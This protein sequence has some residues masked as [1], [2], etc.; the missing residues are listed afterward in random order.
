MHL[1]GKTGINFQMALRSVLKNYYR[2]LNKTFEMPDYYGGDKK[3]DGWVV[4]DGLFYQIYGPTRLK[5]SLKK[6]IHDK[7]DE[8]LEGLM[9]HI[10]KD[11]LWGGILKHFIFIVNDF[12]NN[13]PEDSERYYQNKILEMRKK[14]SVYFEGGVFDLDYIKNL[15]Y[16]IKDIEILE[17]ISSELAITYK[18]DY[19]AVT[20]VEM[21]KLIADISVKLND[22]ILFKKTKPS[23]VRVS[24]VKKIKI[25]DLAGKREE[26]ETIMTYLY[27]V[28]DAINTINQDVL[29]ENKFDQVKQLIINIYENLASS[30]HGIE[31][32]DAI[33]K[34]IKEKSCVDININSAI[35]MLVV[36]IFDKCD[37]FEKE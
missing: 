32:F 24:T 33:I 23:Y 36:Y 14:Y 29:F 6:S 13:L 19:N 5:L 26:I 20:S 8:D 27:V 15:L 30:F 25:N 2:G 7:F 11:K 3:N 17:R 31:L 34:E 12:D 21:I 22:S 28:E 4:D 16:N 10:Y 1:Q 37:I 9:K 18:W 35:K